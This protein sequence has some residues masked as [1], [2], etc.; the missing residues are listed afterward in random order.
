MTRNDIPEAKCGYVCATDSYMSGWGPASGK[1]NRLI[2]V[3]DTPEEADAVR[4]NCEAR[5]E[6]KRVT[7][8]AKKPSLNNSRNFYQVKTKED[9]PNWY[10]AG[11][12][13]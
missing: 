11:Y 7:W 5:S 6:F 2:F 4:G 10:K 12:F 3:C 9:Y 1:N 8:N 13:S